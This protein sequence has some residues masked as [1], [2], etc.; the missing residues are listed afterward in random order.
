MTHYTRILAAWAIV[1]LLTTKTPIKS[2]AAKRREYFGE[3]R[4]APVSAD[5]ILSM[6]VRRGTSSSLMP[7]V[8]KNDL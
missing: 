4:P 2:N 6:T 1:E 8:V 5:S 3:N 7:R